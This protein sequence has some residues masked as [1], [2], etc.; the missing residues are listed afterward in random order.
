MSFTF[1][2][3]I[4]VIYILKFK[5]EEEHKYILILHTVDPLQGH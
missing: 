1:H 4:F 5:N 2:I 3:L